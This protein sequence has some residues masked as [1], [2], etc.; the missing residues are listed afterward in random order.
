MAEINWEEI[1]WDAVEASAI[2][3]SSEKRKSI[4]KNEKE[5]VENVSNCNE[6]S[7]ERIESLTSPRSSSWTFGTRLSMSNATPTPNC[8]PSTLLKRAPTASTSNTSAATIVEMD[9]KILA[10]MKKYWG[11]EQLRA[12]QLE[13]VRHVLCHKDVLVLWAT[14]W[15]K[16]LCYQLPPLITN[17]TAIVVSPLVSLMNDQVN[18]INSKVGSSIACLVGSMQPDKQVEIDAQ[19]GRYRLVYVTPEKLCGAGFAERLMPLYLRDC[20]ELFAVDEAHCCS[21]SRRFLPSSL[22]P[23]LLIIDRKRSELI[24]FFIALKSGGTTTGRIS[25]KSDRSSA[26]PCLKCRSSL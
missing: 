19:E 9:A 10:T 3:E 22:P 24:A 26:M 25:S 11:Y 18:A 20:I 1:D 23:L 5:L 2:Q 7:T 14:G 12:G 15:G 17:K 16:S 4:V 8:M 6:P 13:V 21:G